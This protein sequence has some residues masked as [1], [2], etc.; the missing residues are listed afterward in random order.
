MVPQYQLVQPT[1]CCFEPDYRS[2]PQSVPFHHSP[3]GRH[4]FFPTLGVSV[5]QLIEFFARLAKYHSISWLSLDQRYSNVCRDAC[6]KR[7]YKF[8][9]YNYLRTW[10]PNPAAL[11]CFNFKGNGWFAGTEILNSKSLSPGGISSI[12]PRRVRFCI[13]ESLLAS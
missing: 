13:T 6:R 10:A 3:V 4:W 5:T 11:N 9:L 8:I 1:I 2:L 7:L 12:E